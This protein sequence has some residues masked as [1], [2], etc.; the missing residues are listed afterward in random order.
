MPKK[1]ENSA[2]TKREP[3]IKIPPKIVAPEREV[4]GIKVELGRIQP[5][6]QIDT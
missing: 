6:V 4:P 1:N 2:D 5:L 3:P